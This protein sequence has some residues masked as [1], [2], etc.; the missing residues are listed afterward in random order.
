MK[1]RMI[2][3]IIC[4]FAL[5]FQAHVLA[6]GGAS[7]G[8]GQRSSPTAARAN[9]K[10]KPVK[11]QKQH[12]QEK[13]DT[14]KKEGMD[15]KSG[16]GD[17]IVDARQEHQKERIQEGIRSGQLTQDEIHQLNEGQK[18]IRKEEKQY[19]SD[20]NLTK[21]ERKDL[22]KDLNKASKEI[23]QEKHD[24][25]TRP[26]S[27]STP[28]QP[29]SKQDAG[30]NQSHSSEKDHSQQGSRTIEPIKNDTSNPVPKEKSPKPDSSHSAPE[31]SHP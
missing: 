11:N 21:E 27:T 22:R 5:M 31:P 1:S 15:K 7:R 16:T 10:D 30:A 9:S 13:S 26:G 8:S 14:K 4:T 6:R 2:L 20:G 19:Q 28:P 18:Q 25:E 23:Y 24:T 29:P 17:R 12:A 3:S